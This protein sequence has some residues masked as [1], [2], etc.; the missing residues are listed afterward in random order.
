MDE[1]VQQIIDMI[2]ALPYTD[3]LVILHTLHDELRE[4][5]HLEGGGMLTGSMVLLDSAVP[6]GMRATAG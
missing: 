4:P 2:R 6:P 3:R 1:Q 5:E